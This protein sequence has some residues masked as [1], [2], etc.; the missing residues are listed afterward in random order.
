MYV[1]TAM[2]KLLTRRKESTTYSPWWE[3]SQASK[4]GTLTVTDS[5]PHNPDFKYYATNATQSKQEGKMNEEEYIEQAEETIK[6][7]KEY[8]EKERT[9]SIQKGI[10]HDHEKP[11]EKQEESKHKDSFYQASTNKNDDLKYFEQKGIKYDAE[12]PPMDLISPFAME[13]VAKVLAFGKK[14]YSARN[15]ENGFNWTRAIGAILRHTFAYLRGETHDPETK[16][17]HMAHVLCEAMFLVHFEQTH[18]ELDD[19][20]SYKEKI[21]KY[22]GLK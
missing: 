5:L 17:S 14:K 22:G 20:P 11:I 1:V 10:K 7:A 21:D 3:I 18:P 6:A 15:W 9:V 16:L 13:E 2:R 4:D 8:Y 19:R 12:K